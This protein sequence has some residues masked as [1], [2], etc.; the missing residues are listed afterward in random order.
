MGS[1]GR[2]GSAHGR[3]EEE[4]EGKHVSTG[5]RADQPAS[6]WA[7][8]CWRRLPDQARRPPRGPP[9][10]LGLRSTWIPLPVRDW[11]DTC[12]PPG[13]WLPSSEA[14]SELPGPEKALG[15]QFDMQAACARQGVP[16][17]QGQHIDGICSAIVRERL[18]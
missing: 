11:M 17:R 6:S 12:E 16:E 15:R 3:A 10:R 7:Q 5:S 18:R 2:E 8:T 13:P 4:E 1:E 9:E 14:C